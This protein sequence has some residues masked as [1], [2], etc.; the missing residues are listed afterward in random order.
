[1]VKTT[2]LIENEITKKIYTTD[3]EFV[4]L[5]NSIKD[6]GILEPLIVH[7]IDDN[8]YEVISGN[9]RLR[10]SKK[11]DLK[12]VPVLIQKYKEITE[13]LIVSHQQQRIK[14]PS[15]IIKEI[16]IL[17]NKYGLKQ[18]VRSDINS[19]T[20]KGKEKKQELFDRY[21]KTKVDRL[22]RINKLLDILEESEPGI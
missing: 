20:Q 7:P 21:N 3:D 2:L 5:F 6:K 18:G 9:R 22:T 4:E 12:K 1:M 11:L 14:K 8:K 13:E 15:D 16:M 17:N 19:K 10:V